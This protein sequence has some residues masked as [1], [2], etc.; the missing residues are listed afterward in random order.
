MNLNCGVTLGLHRRRTIRKGGWRQGQGVGVEELEVGATK[1]HWKMMSTEH[2]QGGIGY[3]N[4]GLGPAGSGGCRHT[5]RPVKENPQM[6]R[7]MARDED[8]S[9]PHRISNFVS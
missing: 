8:E 6:E 1:V 4:T 9:R 2:R 5:G 3:P 7:K